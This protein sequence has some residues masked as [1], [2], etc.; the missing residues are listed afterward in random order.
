MPGKIALV[1]YNRCQPDLCD[2]CPAASACTRKLLVQESRHEAPMVNPSLCKGCGD[3]VRACPF[4][5]II[6]STQ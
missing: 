5:A 4:K 6:I 1:D 3:C 2:H